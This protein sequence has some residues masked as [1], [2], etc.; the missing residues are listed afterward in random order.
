MYHF[1]GPSLYICRGRSPDTFLQDSETSSKMKNN[2]H[3]Q[4]KLQY[5]KYALCRLPIADHICL[6]P[7]ALLP[8][9][10]DEARVLVCVFQVDF[11]VCPVVHHHSSSS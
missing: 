8:L 1:L 5:K 11:A 3:S 10:T 4:R 2:S 9:H 7:Y 6:F